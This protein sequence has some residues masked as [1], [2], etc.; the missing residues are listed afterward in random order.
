MSLHARSVAVA[1][2]AQ[3]EEVERVA[4]KI[5]EEGTV[6]LEAAEQV[7]AGLRR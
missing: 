3:G 2:G 7:L 6:T 5:C 1:A 4:E